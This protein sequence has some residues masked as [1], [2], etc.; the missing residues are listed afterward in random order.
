MTS[1]SEPPPP[2]GAGAQEE[3]LGDAHPPHALP[4]QLDLPREAEAVPEERPAAK[5]A[6]GKLNVRRIVV[7]L[8]LLLVVLGATAA[9]LVA[10]V[11]PWYVRRQC[12]EEAAAHG[13]A[14]AIDD[15]KIDGGG[16]HLLGVRATWADMPG[17]R[18]RA[19]QV[20]V[21]TSGLRPQKMTVHG[22]EV[23]LEGHWNAVDTTFA[24]WSASP[25]GGQ[26]G[27]W[28]PVALAFEDSRIV[29]QAPLG[30]NAGVEASGVHLDVTTRPAGAEL[31]ARSERVTIGVPG[32]TLG[33]WRVDLDRT[34]GTSRVRIALDPGV[35]EA[36]TVLV[37]GDD[38][39]TTSVDISVPRSPLARL[40]LPPQLLGL[41]GTDLQAEATMHY[42]TQGPS[43][44][45]ATA[46]GGL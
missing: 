29:W 5:R 26:G 24:K 43:R 37:V 9:A 8:A 16:F 2:S 45:D 13:I 20:D 18:I 10:Y 39:R 25:A 36:C 28:V 12:I 4:L 44:A 3:S 30:E 34:P 19:P 1:P 41:R 27:A 32:G 17:A 7:R 42:A 33:P 11:L 40:G 6:R 46:K 15:A 31:H 14:L 21:E 35:P 23:T 38:E 22:A